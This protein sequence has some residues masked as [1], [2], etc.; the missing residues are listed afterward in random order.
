[1]TLISRFV[2]LSLVSLLFAS[3]ILVADESRKITKKVP[4]AY[5][6]I[7]RENHV[8][9]EVKMEVDVAADG[10]VKKAKVLAGHPLLTQ[11]AVSAVQQW[12]FEP[13]ADSTVPVVVNFK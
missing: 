7:A 9:G 12:K 3:T 4:P 13:G 10:S 2:R 8:V 1:M 5:P 6:A 11:A